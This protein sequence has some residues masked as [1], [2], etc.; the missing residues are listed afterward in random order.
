MKRIIFESYNLPSDQRTKVRNDQKER[1]HFLGSRPLTRESYKELLALAASKQTEQPGANGTN[2]G[3]LR[4][5]LRTAVTTMLG[6]TIM[7]TAIVIVPRLRRLATSIN[8]TAEID[9][10]VGVGE[11][12]HA[13]N[14]DDRNK[15]L[16]HFVSPDRSTME[17]GLG[18]LRF[19]EMDQ[20]RHE[21]QKR[22]S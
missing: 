6:S 14:C 21:A 10:V 13:R 18:T 17:V 11:R 22:V 19:Q 8:G 1:A 7:A 3:R 20:T 16:F 12:D 5:A 15:N 2:A 4:N 9:I